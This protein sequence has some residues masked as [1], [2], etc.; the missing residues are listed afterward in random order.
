[1]NALA[2]EREDSH[3]EEAFEMS[4]PGALVRK[5]GEFADIFIGTPTRPLQKDDIVL[6]RVS[7]YETDVGKPLVIIEDQQPIRSA[8]GRLGIRPDNTIVVRLTDYGRQFLVPKYLFY[9]LRAGWQA[10][11]WQ[12]YVHGTVQQFL[13][14]DYVKDFPLG[15][16]RAIEELGPPP[17][18]QP[19]RRYRVVESPGFTALP[20]RMKTAAKLH[21]EREYALHPGRTG[22]YVLLNAEVYAEFHPKIQCPACGWDV[23]RRKNEPIWECTQCGA[24]APKERFIQKEDVLEFYLSKEWKE[25]REFPERHV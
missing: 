11:H 7:G 19:T 4:E 22:L 3:E 14:A 9:R 6:Q 16:I 13:R 12:K 15:G 10:G 25:R 17:G 21:F 20:P 8:R 5:L 1:M 23:V 2:T 18:R 24:K